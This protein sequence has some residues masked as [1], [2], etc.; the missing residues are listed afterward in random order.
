M[1]NSI[2]TYNFT[3]KQGNSGTLQNERGIELNLKDKDGAAVDLSGWD[4]VFYARYGSDKLTLSSADGAIAV[5]A[6]AG[7][8]TIPIS[9]AHSRTFRAGTNVRY[10]IERSKGDDQRTIIEGVLHILEGIN[11]D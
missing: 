3:L 11:D 8:I 2:P 5:D 7:A 9:V 10:E 4:V 1:S 6:A